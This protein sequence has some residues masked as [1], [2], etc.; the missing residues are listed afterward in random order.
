MSALRFHHVFFLLMLLAL[1]SALTLSPERSAKLTPQIQTL[2]APIAR[3][4]AAIGK[5]VDARLHKPPAVD[6]RS[7]DAI[8]AENEALQ[9]SV[10]SLTAQLD[11]LKILNRDRDLL[12]DVRQ[13]TRTYAVIGG[14]SGTR[15][16][17][18]I[19]GT[20]LTQDGLKVGQPVI[21]LGGLVGQVS[22]A[23]VAGAKITLITDPS[24]ALTGSFGRFQQG[25][26]GRQEFVHLRVGKTPSVLVTGIG[27][28]SLVVNT[29]TMEEAAPV[30]VRDL[31]VLADD[32]WPPNLQGYKI[33]VVTAKEPR[34]DSPLFAK[35]TVQPSADLKSLKDVSVVVK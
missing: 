35:I 27:N 29:L 24:L 2:F 34:P 21:F 12:G 9:V 31:V 4:A 23:G 32:R 16:T 19:G 1:I 17:L 18:Q 22:Q 25:E 10:A 7:G 5:M 28:N 14:D 20:T 6:P 15:Q 11:A 13:L 33:G 26:D 3:P 8:R 30:Q